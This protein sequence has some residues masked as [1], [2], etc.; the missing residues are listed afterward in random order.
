[1]FSY[2]YTAVTSWATYGASQRFL[3]AK[4]QYS[5]HPVWTSSIVSKHSRES[6]SLAHL[7][8]YIKTTC[9]VVSGS[10]LYTALT[11]RWPAGRPQLARWRRSA[12]DHR[13]PASL[14]TYMRF[15]LCAPG[16]GPSHIMYMFQPCHLLSSNGTYSGGS[17]S[18]AQDFEK[19]VLF[20]KKVDFS[21]GGEVDLLGKASMHAGARK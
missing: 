2:N 13:T 12:L 6:M 3:L 14:G 21:R 11:S 16:H 20:R 19:G 7:I 4:G 17:R 10:R 8:N 15:E 1:M 18:L 5:F 9:S